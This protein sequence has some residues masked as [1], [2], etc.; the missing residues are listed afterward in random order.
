MADDSTN[1]V[2]EISKADAAFF[3]AFNSCD[4]PAMEKILSKDLEF[5]HDIVGV[6]GHRDTLAKTKENCDKNLGLRRDL[7]EGSLEVHPI[8]DFG[9]LEKGRHTFCHLENGE[10]VCGTF[11]FMHIWRRVKEGWELARVI[12]YGH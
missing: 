2:D 9:A 7:L 1:L 6:S 8:G 5:Y 3:D 10:N 12:S 4:L 11:E